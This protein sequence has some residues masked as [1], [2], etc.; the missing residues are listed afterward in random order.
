MDYS[1]FQVWQLQPQQAFIGWMYTTRSA[2]EAFAFSIEAA[3]AVTQVAPI[4]QIREL[5]GE[6]LQI[7]VGV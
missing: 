2:A 3:A 7:R 4:H 5:N 1:F 6:P